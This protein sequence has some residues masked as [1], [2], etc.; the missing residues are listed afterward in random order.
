MR[1]FR[2]LQANFALP[3]VVEHTKRPGA[4]RRGHDPDAVGRDVVGAERHPSLPHEVTVRSV[5]AD[6]AV[7]TACDEHESPGEGHMLRWCAATR[8]TP[9]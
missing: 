4:E 9:K 8:S 1:C 5:D 2:D 7:V 3:A 6:G